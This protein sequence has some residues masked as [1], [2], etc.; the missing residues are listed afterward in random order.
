MIFEIEGGDKISEPDEAK[1]K[2]AIRKLRS[3]GPQSFASLDNED[4][5]YVQVA[6]GGVTC[7]LERM[8]GVLN[9]QYRGY[10]SIKS[11]VFPDGT[12]LAF[13]GGELIMRSDEWFSSE[14]VAE[15]FCCFLRK[16]PFPDYVMWRE[17]AA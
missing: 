15:V 5:E 12:I 1:V 9:K 14:E 3:Y 13:G 4:G 8:D 6:G 11:K 16:S 17:I 7:M 10:T 2:L